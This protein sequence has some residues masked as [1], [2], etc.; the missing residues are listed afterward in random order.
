MSAVVDT[1]PL[2]E[3]RLTKELANPMLR[4]FVA[5]IGLVGYVLARSLTVTVEYPPLMFWGVIIGATGTVVLTIAYFLRSKKYAMSTVARFLVTVA[6][7][8]FAIVFGLTWLLSRP[9]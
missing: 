8:T 9:S 5:S 6:L 4:I 1:L 7:V 3:A 2:T